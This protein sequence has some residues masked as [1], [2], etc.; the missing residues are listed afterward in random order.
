MASSFDDDVWEL[1]PAE[2]D[3]A[4][5]ASVDFVA[6]LGPVEAAVDIGCGDGL[7]TA[8]LRAT[9]IVAADVSPVALTRA[10]ARLGALAETVELEPDSPL[11]F[12]DGEFDLVLLT[13]TLEH[14][15]DVQLLLSEV[16]RVLSPGG[17]VAITTEAHGRL[18]GLR[19][20]VSGFD[21]AFPPLSPHLRF[22]S[23]ASLAHLLE[24]LG[25]DVVDIERRRGVL[26]ARANR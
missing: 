23:R 21:G 7:L 1:V 6:G 15:R 26:Y 3:A 18:T 11:P 20:L 12:S 5:A 22:F 13:D 8:E 4:P 16:R 2:R 24:N 19:V 14:V 9:R 10:R 25:F 17:E